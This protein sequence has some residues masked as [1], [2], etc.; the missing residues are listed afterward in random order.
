M[1]MK[2]WIGST[3]FATAIV[4]VLLRSGPALAGDPE[5][6]QT[7][8]PPFIGQRL[9]DSFLPGFPRP[10]D[11]PYMTYLNAGPQQRYPFADELEKGA[12][13]SQTSPGVFDGSGT[14][15]PVGNIFK[16]KF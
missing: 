15:T 4:M 16:F 9:K 7:H 2:T 13:M 6:G 3:A 5:E 11:T 8:R 12:D 10:S 1:H 14:P